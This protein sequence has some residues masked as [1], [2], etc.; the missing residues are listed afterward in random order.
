MFFPSAVWPG[1]FPWLCSVT[2][3]K[4]R[5]NPLTVVSADPS[6]WPTSYPPTC[7]PITPIACPLSAQSSQFLEHSLPLGIL[8]LSPALR[9][10]STSSAWWILLFPQDSV[11][12]SSP[13]ETTLSAFFSVS[14]KV[15][16]ASLSDFLY[17]IWCDCLC[18]YLPPSWPM[19]WGSPWKR[20]V[21]APHGKMHPIT[22]SPGPFI[23]AT[24]APCSAL[25]PGHQFAELG[26]QLAWVE[27]MEAGSCIGRWL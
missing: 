9:K 16:Y 19:P 24:I 25:G 21:W 1:S 8:E 14:P 4:T 18:I 27:E 7:S 23:S 12:I 10:S 3:W 5:T 2:V 13:G 11:Q 15:F 26:E 17:S 6:F 22:P 20:P